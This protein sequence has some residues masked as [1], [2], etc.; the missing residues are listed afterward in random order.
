MDCLRICGHSA[1]LAPHDDIISPSDKLWR[2]VPE[3]T[4]VQQAYLGVFL[5]MFDDRFKTRI[6]RIRDVPRHALLAMNLITPL[7]TSGY[8]DF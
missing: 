5:L 4:N 3:S 8:P 6:E 2:L 1:F 7:G